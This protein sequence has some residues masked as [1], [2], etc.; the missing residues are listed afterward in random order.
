MIESSDSLFQGQENIVRMSVCA[1]LN[2]ISKDHF[3]HANPFLSIGRI[4]STGLSIAADAG[5]TDSAYSI[6]HGPMMTE[7]ISVAARRDQSKG[8]PE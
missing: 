8:E 7:E 2:E 5:T 4:G 1:R 6:A 3:Y